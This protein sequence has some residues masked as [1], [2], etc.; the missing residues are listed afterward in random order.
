MYVWCAGRKAARFLGFK[1]RHR[2][3]SGKDCSNRKNATAGMPEG[4]TEVHRLLSIIE[5]ICEPAG[6]KGNAFIPVNE[7]DR[8]FYGL[9]RQIRHSMS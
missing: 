2:G 8:N 3:E 1:L 7:K 4:Y 9:L 6:R 5:Q